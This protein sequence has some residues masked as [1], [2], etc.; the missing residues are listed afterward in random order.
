MPSSADNLPLLNRLSTLT[1]AARLRI[2]R[3]LDKQELSVGE[4][5]RALQLPQSTVS[6]HLKLLHDAGWTTKRSEGTASLY[7][8]AHAALDPDMR[9]LWQLARAQL[10]T[11][12]TFGQD[13]ARLEQVLA[14]RR[15]DSR[16]FFGKVAGDW[17]QLRRELFGESFTAQALLSLVQHDWVAADLGCGTGNA[18]EQLAPLV[19]KVIAIDRE[20]AMLDA[21]RKRLAELRDGQVEFRQG[22]LT[23]L[24]LRDGEI[25]LALMFLVLIYI[26]SP[27]AALREV[28]RALQPGGTALIV[29]LVPHDRESYRHTLGHVHL[30]F[31]ERQLKAWAKSAGLKDVRYRHL[32]PDIDSKGPALFAATMRKS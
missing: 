1:D 28:A 2:L 30:G 6:R 11:T 18:A 17:D 25:D 4:L 20:P 26:E 9:E 31:D 10:G 21:A 8:L 15:T 22:E 14:E 12:R 5:S 23:K 29:D 19:K 16:A 7:R 32:R 13:D 27:E 3:L 24:P